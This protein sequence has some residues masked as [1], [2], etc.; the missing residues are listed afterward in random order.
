MDVPA[1]VREHLGEES[2]E[3]TVPLGE[4]DA[5]YVTP[6]RTLHYTGEGLFSDESVAEYRHDIERLDLTEGRRKATFTLTAVDGTDSLS[7]PRDHVGAV[8]EPLLGAILETVGPIEPDESVLEAYRF[9][10]LTLVLT[11]RRL[12]KHVGEAVWDADYEAY[13]YEDLTGLAFEEGSVAT[14]IVLSVDGHSERIKAPNADAPLLERTLTEAV[15]AVHGVDSLAALNDLLGADA[16]NPGPTDPADSDVALDESIAPL[17]GR[18]S[19][20]PATASAD[21]PGEALVPDAPTETAPAESDVGEA[22]I[23]ATTREPDEVQR[24]T[25][26]SAASTVRDRT[27]TAGG[28]TPDE[29]QPIRTGGDEGTDGEADPA[30]STHS[31][32]NIAALRE[33]VATLS[34]TLDRQATLLEDQRRAIEVLEAHLDDLSGDQSED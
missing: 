22:R 11:D 2:P 13:A 6:T 16:P 20:E 27:G 8:L 1:L 30:A 3:A 28:D 29:E 5:L 23:D 19:D 17:V 9:S 32:A 25:E 33:Q 12:V 24:D 14:Q 7:V 21:G 10:E 26:T 34:E 31:A 4:D 18:E 15:C